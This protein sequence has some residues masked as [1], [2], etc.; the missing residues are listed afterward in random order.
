MDDDLFP[1]EVGDYMTNILDDELNRFS[2]SAIVEFMDRNMEG[3]E[4]ML[5]TDIR[6]ENTD[7][8]VLTILGTLKA[9]MGLVPYKAEKVSDRVE[10]SG[11]YMPLYKF[12]KVKTKR[13]G[14]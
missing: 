5:T 7:E 8:L 4:E 3:K 11:Y 10:F 12:T 1:D 9:M 14:R 2:D 13:G 6:V